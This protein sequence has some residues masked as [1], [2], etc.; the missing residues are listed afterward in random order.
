MTTADFIAQVAQHQQTKPKTVSSVYFDGLHLYS[1]GT[2][3]PLL[4]NCKGKWIV[5]RQGYSNTTAK[6]ISYATSY[7]DYKIAIPN[8]T[9]TSRTLTQQGLAEVALENI[10]TLQQ[11]YNALKRK[12]TKKAQAILDELQDYQ[13]TYTFLATA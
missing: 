1:Y 2:H 7:A 9:A 4:I 11:T 13:A 12:T 8:Y 5:N 6:H 10:N 3:Y